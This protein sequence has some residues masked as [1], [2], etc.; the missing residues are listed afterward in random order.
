MKKAEI[1]TN[2][3]TNL[4][5]IKLEG[6]SAEALAKAEKKPTLNLSTDPGIVS[7]R[8]DMNSFMSSYKTV[9]KFRSLF[10]SY[11]EDINSLDTKIRAPKVE[12]HFVVSST[13]D[14]YFYQN[15]V[16]KIKYPYY[17]LVGLC[18]QWEKLYEWYKSYNQQTVNGTIYD[19][20]T[21]WK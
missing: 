14:V 4:P 20:I 21:E 12:C 11:F 1:I 13:I 17:D 6:L 10:C 15:N 8:D 7:I 19:D 18:A 3:N 9:H 2:G 16:F 5:N